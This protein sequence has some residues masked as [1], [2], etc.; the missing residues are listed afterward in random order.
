MIAL[1]AVITGVIL[2]GF[3]LFL[4]NGLWIYAVWDRAKR[5]GRDSLPREYE[6]PRYYTLK[7]GGSVDCEAKWPG[8]DGWYF[9]A[10]PEAPDLPFRMIRASLMTGLYGLEGIDNYERLKLR[11]S[12]AD[13]AE[14]L[15]LIPTAVRT[16]S[17]I[18]Q[19]NY[20][21]QHYLPKA[22]GLRMSAGTLDIAMS[23]EDVSNDTDFLQYGRIAGAWPDYHLQ[24]YN[25]EANISAD[26][27]FHGERLIWWA[28]VPGLFTYA[29]CLGR[30]DGTITYHDG[31]QKPDPHDIPDRPEDSV[32]YQIRGR[33]G[34]EHGFARRLFSAN[35][36]FLPIRLLKSAIPS[37][38]AIR[39]QYEVMTGDEGPSGGFMQA[40]AFGVKVRDRG[41]LYLDSRYVPIDGV[42]IRH[43]SEPPPDV[44]AAHCPA[45]PA[46]FYRRWVVEAKTPEGLLSYTGSREW[47]PAPVAANMTYYH[48]TY[49]GTYKGAVIRGRGYGEYLNI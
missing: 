22:S 3:L 27:R 43:L 29:T 2:V 12:P 9:F 16:P 46:T 17:G 31:I 28:D 35:G 47:P 21:S 30:Y 1:L 26:L 23:G 40:S 36:L 34:F 4:F 14:A 42:Q 37:F 11:L 39:Y 49:E 19:R 20:L 15:S 32:T 5:N 7:N 13:A 8:W 48:F 33:G 18:E 38:H 41:G 24:S 6:I 25:P 45:S 44:V 10:I